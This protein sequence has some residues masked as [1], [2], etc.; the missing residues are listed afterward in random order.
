MQA[1]W[2]APKGESNLAKLHGRRSRLRKSSLWGVKGKK[3]HC[4]S[5]VLGKQGFNPFGWK[6]EASA[7][8]TARA[9][10]PGWRGR[11][12]TQQAYNKDLLNE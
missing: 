9:S 8:C 7:L 10:K 4:P 6:K 2:D 5:K 3:E 12:H 11:S 1:R